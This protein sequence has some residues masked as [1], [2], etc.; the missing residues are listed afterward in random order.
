MKRE[1]DTDISFLGKIILFFRSRKD[2]YN[3]TRLPQ[4]IVNKQKELAGYDCEQSPT[5]AK[6]AFGFG[7]ARVS[8]ITVL[9]IFLA[10][11]LLFGS[12]IMSYENVYYMFKDISYISSFSE[13]RPE[14]LGYSQ[15]VGNQAFASFKNGLAVAGDS[16][17]K[18]FTST[19]RVT[20]SAGS[21]Y[22]NPQICT[23]DAYILIYDQG[24]SSFSV[25]NSFI[26][27]YSETL[28]YP[29]SSASMAKDGSFIIVTKSSTYRSAVRIYNKKFKLE[30]EY[31][32]NDLVISAELSSNGKHI[33][34]ASLD[35]EGGEAKVTLSVL[36]RG[37]KNLKSS[38]VITDSSVPY[39]VA[40]LSGNR[41]ALVC[42]ES[43]SVYDLNGNRKNI[44]PYP[45]KL[46][47]VADTSGGIALLF[48]ESGAGADELLVAFDDNGDMKITAKISGNVSDMKMNKDDIFLLCDG[49]IMRV[50]STFGHTSTEEFSEEGARLVLTSGGELIACTSSL[51]Y[52]VSFD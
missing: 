20:M 18:L 25:Y 28:D 7:M 15:S 4:R 48:D 33:A 40:F 31:L 10:A 47:R 41:I 36:E 23:S 46:S 39:S 29:I 37:K 38:T 8:A 30:S 1:K 49:K 5:E 21:K 3:V 16:E 2:K 24:S 6:I 32:K 11:V 17:I 27:V 34:I 51:A 42:S 45:D 9:C 22:T 26:C 50:D 43:L 44:F 19:G 12:S 14:T 35:A 52:Y 13:T